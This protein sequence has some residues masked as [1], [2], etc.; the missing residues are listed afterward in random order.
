VITTHNKLWIC[1]TFLILYKKIFL[2]NSRKYFCVN[3]FISSEQLEIAEQNRF[4]ATELNTLIPMQGKAH[5]EKFYTKNTW[6]KNYFSKF[7]TDLNLVP[8]IKK[9]VVF[10][11][12][13][14]VL[15]D[16]IVGDA[17]DYFFQIS[18]VDQVE[19]KIRLSD[20]RRFQNCFKINAKYFKTPSFQ[21]SKKSYLIFECQ[22][23]RS[24]AE[25]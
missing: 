5:F 18:Y 4:T 3:Y 6:V 21:F 8:D 7:N 25:I 10:R 12:S 11:K 9:T 24:A 13:I 22:T 14:E 2:L 17:L 15:F 1:R 19:S 23:R 16:N 20:R